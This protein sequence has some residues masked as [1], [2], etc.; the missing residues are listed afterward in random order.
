[1]DK[2]IIFCG[3]FGGICGFLDAT[4]FIKTTLAVQQTGFGRF[5][6]CADLAIYPLMFF[7]GWREKKYD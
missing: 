4:I 2:L 6:L 3:V 7:L 1:M 5:G